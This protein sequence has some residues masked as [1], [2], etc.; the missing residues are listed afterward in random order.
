MSHHILQRL[1]FISNIYDPYWFWGLLHC[2]L[3]IPALPLDLQFLKNWLS[4]VTL[5]Y[6]YGMLIASLHLCLPILCTLLLHTLEVISVTGITWFK[7][8]GNNSIRARI[9]SH[10]RGQEKRTWADKSF[11]YSLLCASLYPPLYFCCE[12]SKNLW[13]NYSLPFLGTVPIPTVNQYL[14]FLFAPTLIYRD[15]YPR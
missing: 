10:F 9:R 15:S 13:S 1:C 12:K 3:T 8:T 2:F 14:Y 11:Y 4:F 5:H 7:E 6:F